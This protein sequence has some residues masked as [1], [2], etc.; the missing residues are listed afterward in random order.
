M[1]VRLYAITEVREITSKALI[2]PRV[3]ISW[4]AA[5]RVSTLAA[6]AMKR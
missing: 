4:S 5:D 2:C 1:R 6:S 3:A